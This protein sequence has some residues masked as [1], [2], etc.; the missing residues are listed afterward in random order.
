LDENPPEAIRWYVRRL[1]AWWRSINIAE[2][3]FNRKMFERYPVAARVVEG[4]LEF[5]YGILASPISALIVALLLVGL[6]IS[7]VTGVIVSLSAFAA[8]FVFVVAIPRQPAIK[9]LPIL[10]RIFICALCACVSFGLGRL[11]VKWVLSEYY[12]HH[13]S[14]VASV[15]VAKEANDGVDQKIIGTLQELLKKEEA[16]YAQ[17]SDSY[18]RQQQELSRATT[19]GLPVPSSTTIINKPRYGDLADRLA[20]LATKIQDFNA[21][22]DYSEASRINQSLQ[23]RAF[24]MKDVRS[25]QQ[26]CAQEHFHSK[27]LDD[28]LKEIDTIDEANQFARANG[29]QVRAYLIQ[30]FEIERI[31]GGLSELSEKIKA[32]S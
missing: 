21:K 9:R 19:K 27:D 18:R 7:E 31:A 17:L 10:R 29:Q 28:T 8:W 15:P 22:G 1:K 26:E 20:L 5:I 4:V 25:L 3:R 13:G 2:I 23:F 6:V 12:I 16:K 24:Y 30:S 11:Y 32:A 14:S